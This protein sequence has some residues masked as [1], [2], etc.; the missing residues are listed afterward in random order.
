MI[1]P[2]IIVIR[3]AIARGVTAT[4]EELEV[5]PLTVHHK[6]KLYLLEDAWEE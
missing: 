3:L 1:R 5:P 2:L 4:E 6:D